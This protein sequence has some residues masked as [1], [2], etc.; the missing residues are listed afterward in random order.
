MFKKKPQPVK[1]LCWDLFSRVL[2]ELSGVLMPMVLAGVGW[3]VIHLPQTL[4][5]IDA[6]QE[7]IIKSQ[8]NFSVQLRDHERYLRNLDS[9]LTKEEY[10][11]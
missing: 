10:K 9:R 3:L 6:Q 5:H 1:G 8:D 7:Q 4:N 2:G 11:D